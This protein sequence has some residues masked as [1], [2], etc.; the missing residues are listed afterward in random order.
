M[1][2]VDKLMYSE[3]EQRVPHGTYQKF[4]TQLLREYF[5]HERLDLFPW[6]NC[7]PSE[8]VIGAEPATIRLIRDALNRD[9]KLL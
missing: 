6:L 5:R 9:G 3:Y 7:L 2:K 8:H 1:D 4:F